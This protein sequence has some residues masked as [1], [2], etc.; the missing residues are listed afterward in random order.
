MLPTVARMHLP[1]H[2]VTCRW[3]LL[4]CWSASALRLWCQWLATILAASHEL[5][6]S[7]QIIHVGIHVHLH[8][9]GSMFCDEVETIRHNGQLAAMCSCRMHL[10]CPSS[11]PLGLPLLRSSTG[12]RWD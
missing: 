8:L 4:A 6:K 10:S 2:C 3:P 12:T 5:M 11:S 1:S 9:N 7:K